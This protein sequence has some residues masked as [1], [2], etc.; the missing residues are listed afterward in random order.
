MGEQD[1][2]PIVKIE[3]KE[4]KFRYKIIIIGNGTVGK[5]SLI[6]KYVKHQI[7]NDYMPTVGASIS[8]Q[9]VTLG[10][11]DDA[12]KVSLL[13]FDVGGQP[14][15]EKLHKVYYQ[16]AKGVIIVFDLTN[17]QSFND[18]SKWYEELGKYGLSKVPIML[19]GNKCDLAANR[20]VTQEQI[21]EKQQTLNLED[22]FETSA[23][24]GKNVDNLFNTLAMKIFSLQ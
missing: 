3:T 22:F 8:K 20:K 21:A 16:G 11:G 19:V 13:I 5:T 12:V 14:R 1:S 2:E 24:D 9:P 23:R 6:R 15:F 17:L 7:D 10:T 18:V 4:N